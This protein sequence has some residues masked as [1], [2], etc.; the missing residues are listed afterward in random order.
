MRPAGTNARGMLRDPLRA[1][2]EGQEL[3][4]FAPSRK[5]PADT[6]GYRNNGAE[7]ALT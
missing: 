3:D 7:F 6:D 5:R 2:G 1:Q 4:C